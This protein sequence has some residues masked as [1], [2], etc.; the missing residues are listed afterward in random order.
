VYVYVVPLL[1]L[2]L[3]LKELNWINVHHEWGA[4]DDAAAMGNL[5]SHNSSIADVW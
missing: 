4:L 2:K 5:F 3:K 1:E